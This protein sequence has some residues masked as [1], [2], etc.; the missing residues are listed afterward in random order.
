[1]YNN[2]DLLVYFPLQEKSKPTFIRQIGARQQPKFFHFVSNEEK[3]AKWIN[4]YAL[5]ILD[6][7]TTL[8]VIF[9]HISFFLCAFLVII[10]I[11]C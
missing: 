10:Y 1:M 7:A 5:N 8:H 2:E 3:I 4:K 11:C 6:L 9:V